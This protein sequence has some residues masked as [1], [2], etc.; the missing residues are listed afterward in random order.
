MSTTKVN[1][2][3]SLVQV[4]QRYG[5][6]VPNTVEAHEQPFWSTVT[7]PAAGFTQQEVAFFN[8]AESASS[9]SVTNMPQASQFPNPTN[10]LVLGAEINFFSGAAPT[11]G[12]GAGKTALDDLVTVM[13]GPFRFRFKI[14]NKVYYE[15]SP[16]AS[17]PPHYSFGSS[18]AAALD[19][20]ASATTVVGGYGSVTGQV[21]GFSGI[22]IPAN[23]IFSCSIVADQT[24]IAL[25]SG[26]AGKIQVKL[27]GIYY[28]LAQ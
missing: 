22:N 23:T 16:L 1:I 14:N 4:L 21:R 25:P 7:Y 9:P 19:D 24:G 3:P 5:A 20:L 28:T 27:R 17:L 6:F 8:V 11:N 12:A 13:T 10:F 2:P 18:Q 26:S 15:D